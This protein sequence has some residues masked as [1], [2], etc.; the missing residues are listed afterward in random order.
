VLWCVVFGGGVWQ[1]GS[2][3]FNCVLSNQ[4]GAWDMMQ[5]RTLVCCCLIEALLP[6]MQLCSRLLPLCLLPLCLLPLCLL[7]LFS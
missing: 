3:V 6:A 1:S 5:M 4:D 7:P 2:T